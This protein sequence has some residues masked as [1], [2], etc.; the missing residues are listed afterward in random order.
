[1]LSYYESRIL[2]DLPSVGFCFK[3]WDALQQLGFKLSEESFIFR[4]DFPELYS[5]KPKRKYLGQYCHLGSW[6]NP[7]TKKGIQKRIDILKETLEELENQQSKK[8]SL[9]VNAYETKAFNSYPL[10]VRK[11]FIRSG[12]EIGLNNLVTNK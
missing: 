10:E 2:N 3:I 1:M 5:K 4:Y 11:A 8:F 9:L 7:R 12:V 6:F